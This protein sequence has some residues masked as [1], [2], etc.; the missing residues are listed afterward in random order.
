MQSQSGAPTV[1]FEELFGVN[2]GYVEQVYA[3]FMAQP[4]AVSDE[5][6][7]FFESHLPAEQLPVRKTPSA[8]AASAAAPEGEPAEAELTPLRGV[9]AKIA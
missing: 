2:A 3:E 9:A 1:D 6:R 7:R 4:D 5:W 8:P